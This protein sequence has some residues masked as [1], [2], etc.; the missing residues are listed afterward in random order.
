MLEGLVRLFK[1]QKPYR[2]LFF[3]TPLIVDIEHVVL[4]Y[5][6]WLFENVYPLVFV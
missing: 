5:S 6:L 3:H 2:L 4:L 1:N